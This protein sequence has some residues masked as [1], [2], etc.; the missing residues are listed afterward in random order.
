[1]AQ[2]PPLQNQEEITESNIPATEIILKEK[3]LL[4]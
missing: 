4:N 1:M 3:I 2:R